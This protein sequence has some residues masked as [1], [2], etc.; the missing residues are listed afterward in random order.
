MHARELEKRSAWR[1]ELW[2]RTLITS[3]PKTIIITIRNGISKSRGVHLQIIPD[4]DVC[5][6]HTGFCTNNFMPLLPWLIDL[7][8]LILCLKYIYH[9]NANFYNILIK[10]R[11]YHKDP[12]LETN[13]SEVINEYLS[14][15]KGNWIYTLQ[16]FLI[17]IFIFS[18]FNFGRSLNINSQYNK[19]S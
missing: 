10:I 3:T 1:E 16:N 6:C 8:F 11:Y 15:I 7:F 4:S 13:K 12:R 14:K 2:S 18:I 5:W 9:V 17:R 19:H